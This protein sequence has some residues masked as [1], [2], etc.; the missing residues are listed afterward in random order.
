VKLRL[1]TSSPRNG[2]PSGA[3]GASVFS[4]VG[5]QPPTDID[6]WVFRGSTGK[7][8]IEVPFDSSSAASTVFITA[9]W[10]NRR[11]ESGPAAQPAFSINLPA[12]NAQPNAG[13]MKIAA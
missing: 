9:F 4:F 6:S 12:G 13:T 3:A 1:T 8:E 11:A 10:F 7:T 5:A 2:K